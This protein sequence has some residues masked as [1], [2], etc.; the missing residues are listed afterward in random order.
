MRFRY[1]IQA[2]IAALGLGAAVLAGV[3]IQSEAHAQ[4]AEQHAAARVAAQRVQQAGA[5]QAAQGLKGS[6][7]AQGVPLEVHATSL[8][9]AAS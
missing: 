9:A 7:A 4:T 1:S 6:P 3:Q 5:T 2:L 8:G